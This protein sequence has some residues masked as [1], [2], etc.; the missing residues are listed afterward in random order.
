MGCRGPRN[1]RVCNCVLHKSVREVLSS[2]SRSG[3]K[4]PESVF[5]RICI[6]HPLIIALYVI[7]HGEISSRILSCCSYTADII[8]RGS[9]GRNSK[10]LG[11]YVPRDLRRQ[12]PCDPFRHVRRRTMSRSLYA[13]EDFAGFVT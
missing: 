6:N 7:A 11:H 12:L 3:V 2:L 1:R 8:A 5:Q 9:G 13:T 4:Y 10:E